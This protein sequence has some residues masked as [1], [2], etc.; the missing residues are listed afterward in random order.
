MQETIL[1]LVGKLP[2]VRPSILSWLTQNQVLANLLRSAASPYEAM[3]RY[4][5]RQIYTPVSDRH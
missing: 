5:G 3:T 2:I 1:L 4:L